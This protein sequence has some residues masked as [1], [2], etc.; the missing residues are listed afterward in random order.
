MRSERQQTTG[1]GA[2]KGGI[3]KTATYWMVVHSLVRGLQLRL[4]QRKKDQRLGNSLTSANQEISGSD[5]PFLIFFACEM[6]AR[7]CGVCG[8]L[9]RPEISIKA[10]DRYQASNH[11]NL[12]HA[13]LCNY[14]H[15]LCFTQKHAGRLR[16]FQAAIPCCRPR[17]E[18]DVGYV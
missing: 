4:R 12:P 14:H 10:T 13:C 3:S 18:I 1:N 2:S 16:Q 8:C 11:A 5:R 9:V 7:Y 15:I 17:S 6:G